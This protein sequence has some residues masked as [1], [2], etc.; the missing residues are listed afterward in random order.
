MLTPTLVC[1]YHASSAPTWRGG[2]SVLLQMFLS[3][4]LVFRVT[5]L[6][7]HFSYERNFVA[8]TVLQGCVPS[9]CL[10]KLLLHGVTRVG[11]Y[12]YTSGFSRAGKI[13][14][15]KWGFFPVTRR[16]LG[17]AR[18][19]RL[20]VLCPRDPGRNWRCRFCATQNPTL[21]SVSI[22]D[23]L[24]RVG[25]APSV[26]PWRFLTTEGT[27]PIYRSA[28]LAVLEVIREGP[29]CH[30]PPL[31]R[32]VF[33]GNSGVF[34]TIPITCCNTSLLTVV[35][36]H[37]N[38]SFPLS[39]STASIIHGFSA[40]Q[41]APSQPR[42]FPFRVSLL[43]PHKASLLTPQTAALPRTLRFIDHSQL[44]TVPYVN[45]QSIKRV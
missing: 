11:S 37:I 30:S 27:I 34:V 25:R 3:F 24:S 36:S 35:W 7:W 9:R 21:G 12:L 44:S 19:G 18:R 6:S 22:M 40:C 45:R 41:P 17:T 1:H 2:A 16:A 14:Q 39:Q 38:A 26:V 43:S 15:Q 31:D 33:Y 42:L 28:C 20:I 4:P 5:S 23:V 8:F 13:I 10:I 29:L 32:K